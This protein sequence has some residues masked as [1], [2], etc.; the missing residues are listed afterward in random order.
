LEFYGV[1]CKTKLGF[2]SYPSNRYQTVLIT[3]TNL[4]PNE[5]LTLGRIRHRVPQGSVRGPLLFLLYTNGLP[6]IINDKAV[7]ILFADDNSLLVTSSNYDDLRQKINTVFQ[8]VNEWFKANQLN[9]LCS[10]YS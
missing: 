4:N 1:K 6:K 10:I 3:N 8:D 5:F 7:P 9:S 2:K